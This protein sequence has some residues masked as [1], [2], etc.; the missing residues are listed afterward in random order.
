M[1]ESDDYLTITNN[2]AIDLSRNSLF[3]NMDTNIGHKCFG[4]DNDNH[5]Q[6]VDS[7]II[8]IESVNSGASGL[9]SVVDGINPNDNDNRDNLLK[10]TVVTNY[11]KTITLYDLSSDDDNDEVITCDNET[12]VDNN[13][14]EIIKVKIFD[15]DVD[16]DTDIEVLS[17]ILTPTEVID[18]MRYRL[19]PTHL[20][21]GLSFTAIRVLLNHYNWNPNQLVSD[22]FDHKRDIKLILDHFKIV[23]NYELRFNTAKRLKTFHQT[24]SQRDDSENSQTL[25]EAQSV[26]SIDSSNNNN[27]NN[28]ETDELKTCLVCYDE[29]NKLEMF[30]ANC[31]HFL[32]IDCWNQYIVT[33]V[34]DSSNADQITCPGD[35]CNNIMDDDHILSIIQDTA[36]ADKYRRLISNKF[37]ASE[38]KGLRWCPNGSCLH[39]VKVK[40]AGPQDIECVC[41]TVFCFSCG[42]QWHEPLTCDLFKN[43]VQKYA[44]QAIDPK[45]A[46]W[47]TKHTK[48]CPKCKFPIEK[49]GGCNYVM[50]SKCRHQFCYNCLGKCSHGRCLGRNENDAIE[51]QNADHLYKDNMNS[52][53]LFKEAYQRQTKQLSIERQLQE[54]VALKMERTVKDKEFR[55]SLKFLKSAFTVLCHCRQTLMYCY[56]F[57]Y[58]ARGDLIEYSKRLKDLDVMTTSLSNVL[59]KEAPYGIKKDVCM[60]VKRKVQSKYK[61]CEAKRVALV[62]HIKQGM[63]IN[64]WRIII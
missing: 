36:I 22:Y 24:I 46:K 56:V 14:V 49:N 23:I 11:S 20:T 26:V 51:A 21:T 10:Q 4:N 19:R 8:Y 35:N 57:Q 41:K 15:N 37:I 54:S 61:E 18:L 47:L 58:Y 48:C 9:S 39:A 3:N 53:P 6:S 62:Q 1:Y 25:T 5:Q 16:V 7:D 28:F 33:H 17:E 38:G 42:D 45:S 32:C 43:W 29:L 64:Y 27:N 34:N 59:L 12:T 31:D 13:D 52:F 40:Y 30:G 60:Q 50:C 44:S 2:M 63:S 55:T